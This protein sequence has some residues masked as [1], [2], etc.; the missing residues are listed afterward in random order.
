VTG[1]D[2]RKMARQFQ[3]AFAVRVWLFGAILLGWLLG[4]IEPI[5]RTGL[6]MLLLIAGLV[7]WV[8]A[9]FLTARAN[10]DLL[11]LM[12]AGLADL[13][14]ETDAPGHN[15]QASPTDDAGAPD[16]M[17]AP[18]PSPQNDADP[19][20][21]YHRLC[22]LGDR[23]I[24]HDGIRAM[25]YQQQALMARQLN[26]PTTA[27]AIAA[28][29]LQQPRLRLR[30]SARVDLLLLLAETALNLADRVSAYHAIAEAAQHR[31]SLMQAAQLAML[32]TRYDLACGYYEQALADLPAKVT[33]ADIM[34]YPAAPLT[35]ALLAEA[36]EMAGCRQ[37]HQW[38]GERARLLG[39]A[40]IDPHAA[41][42]GLITPETDVMLPMP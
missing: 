15:E 23:F 4:L 9:S 26:Q 12:Q 38:L 28:A 19:Q 2:P 42:A 22:D 32:R 39:H 21:M 24:L 3:T 33:L 5:G 18:E 37:T 11:R 41:T 25:I 30:R 1:F 29:L 6:P 27:A 10:R 7:G 13:T 8:G 14:G 40:Q 20:A 31:L 34:E 17:D 35:L 36:A 16:D